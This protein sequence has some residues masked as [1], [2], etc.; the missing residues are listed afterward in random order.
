M[1]DQWATD[2]GLAYGDAGA[3]INSA[4]IRAWSVPHFGE[5]LLRR[6]CLEP[7]GLK[8]MDTTS[9]FG[10]RIGHT[11]AA[12]PLLGLQHLRSKSALTPGDYVALIGIG[13]GFT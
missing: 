10:A 8:P 4:A 13:A 3:D 11:G 2:S 7:L 9:Q 12:D 5:T 1:F 6:Q